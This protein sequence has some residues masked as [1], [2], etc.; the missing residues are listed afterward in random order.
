MNRVG[1]RIQK[2]F[3]NLKVSSTHF[4]SATAMALTGNR[5][6]CNTSSTR[7]LHTQFPLRRPFLLPSP[8]STSSWSQGRR[9]QFTVLAA[10]KFISGK[11]KRSSISTKEPVKEEEEEF[12]K[13]NISIDGGATATIDDGFVMPQLPG[14]ETDFWEGPQW[15]GFGFF[16]QY[17]WA[18]GVLF[19]LIACGIAVAT[20]NDGATDF[21]ATPVYKEAIQSGELLEEPEASDSDVFESNPTEEAP[22]LE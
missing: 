6:L 8:S 1:F 21:K 15:D 3:I 14:E 5:I 2:Q 13:I 9:N 20:Y 7:I 18:F 16:V 22:S 11:N 19:S 17:M 12:Q 10:K 4:L